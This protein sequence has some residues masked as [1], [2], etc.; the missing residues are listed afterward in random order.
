VLRVVATENQRLRYDV[1]FLPHF[2]FV[3]ASDIINVERIYVQITIFGL[4]DFRYQAYR[5]SEIKLNIFLLLTV[6]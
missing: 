2:L 5:H 1:F 3:T 4:I 6:L